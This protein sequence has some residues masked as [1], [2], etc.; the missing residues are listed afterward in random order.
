MKLTTHQF[1]WNCHSVR[2]PV[3]D[4]HGQD[5]GGRLEQLDGQDGALRQDVGTDQDQL[6]GQEAEKKRSR[7]TDDAAFLRWIK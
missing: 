2:Q 1:S 6:D 4:A 7:P 3:V 5:G